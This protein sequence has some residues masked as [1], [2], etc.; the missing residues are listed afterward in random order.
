MKRQ[1][2]G[3]SGGSFNLELQGR[4]FIVESSVGQ[5]SVIGTF[6]N[7]EVLVRQGFI[8]PLHAFSAGVLRNALDLKIYPNPVSNSFWIEFRNIVPSEVEI[9]VLDLTG[10]I[11]MSYSSQVNN[12]LQVNM[13]DCTSGIYLIRIESE[14]EYFA[15]KIQKLQ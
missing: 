11:I 10:R 7:S 9:T 5:G 3:V 15:G 13:P 2:L 1:S 4:S 8:Q 14:Q 6:K 12:P